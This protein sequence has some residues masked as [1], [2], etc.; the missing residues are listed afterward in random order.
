MGFC[1]CDLL[2]DEDGVLHATESA[3]DGVLCA[4]ESEGDGVMRMTERAG[5]GVVGC[6]NNTKLGLWLAVGFKP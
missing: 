6:R 1:E 3:G 4:T 5:D 2:I